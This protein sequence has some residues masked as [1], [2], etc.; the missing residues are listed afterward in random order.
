MTL[1]V[2]IRQIPDRSLCQEPSDSPGEEAMMLCR[3]LLGAELAGEVYCAIPG[4]PL[5]V[6]L[7]RTLFRQPFPWDIAPLGILQERWLSALPGDLVLIR[8]S[9]RAV[10]IAWGYGVK[11]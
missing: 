1:L 3:L 10:L 4:S 9:Q 5:L 7:I 6:C 8:Y 2:Y 11:K